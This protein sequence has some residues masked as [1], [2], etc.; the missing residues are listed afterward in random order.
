MHYLQI[1]TGTNIYTWTT[2]TDYRIR[3]AST[4]KW[5]HH[6]VHATLLV[7]PLL[8]TSA[9]YWITTNISATYTSWP[10]CSFLHWLLTFCTYHHLGFIHIYSHTSILHITLPFITFCVSCRRCEMYCGH[11]RLSVCLSVHGRTP[12]LLHGPGCN[13]GAW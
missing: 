10:S 3:A 9:L 8:T 13:L 6:F 11:A 4:N 12:T 2:C 5:L 1:C 7:Y